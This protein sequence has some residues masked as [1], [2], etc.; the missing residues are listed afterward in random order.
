MLLACPRSLG[1]REWLMSQL[2]KN[3]AVRESEHAVTCGMTYAGVTW[4][5][6]SRPNQTTHQPTV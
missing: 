3:G 4:Y 2:S 1:D 6:V 5:H